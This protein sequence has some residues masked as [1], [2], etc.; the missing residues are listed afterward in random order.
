[1]SDFYIYIKLE[2]YLRDWFI[3]ENGGTTPVK[4]RKGSQEH[5][6]LKLFLE[7]LPDGMMPH[8]K[9]PDETT[10]Q[11]PYFKNRDPR[12][13]N[14]LPPKALEALHDCIRTRFTIQLWQDLHTFG[15]IG[16]RND[17]LIY[18]WMHKNGIED[19]ET[20]WNAISKIYYRKRKVYLSKSK[21][22]SKNVSDIDD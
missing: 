2:P 11:L 12:T 16:K 5:D 20:N 22:S 18:A 3:H 15:N 19:T 6:I 17:N 21:K 8:F 14:Y 1:M 4:L 9:Q 10:I 7:K 13:Y